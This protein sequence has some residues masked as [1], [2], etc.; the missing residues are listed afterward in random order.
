MLRSAYWPE[1]SCIVDSA[2]CP[3]FYRRR[4]TAAEYQLVGL[5]VKGQNHD[6][7]DGGHVLPAAGDS[8]A[9]GSSGSGSCS[10]SDA[11]SVSDSPA[12]SPGRQRAAEVR[13]DMPDD[14]R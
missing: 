6:D 3:A 14:Q 11:G 10:G 7:D 8:I 5:A 4:E 2:S 12:G 13:L 9:S 1:L